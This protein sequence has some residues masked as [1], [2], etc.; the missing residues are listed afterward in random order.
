MLCADALQDWRRNWWLPTIAMLTYN[1]FYDVDS[2]S[3]TSMGRYTYFHACFNRKIP[4]GCNKIVNSFPRSRER[5]FLGTNVGAIVNQKRYG[6][7][8][9]RRRVNILDGDGLLP[10]LSGTGT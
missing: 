7:S 5:T 2:P 8:W 6:K 1:Y 9:G 10:S 4:P 3:A